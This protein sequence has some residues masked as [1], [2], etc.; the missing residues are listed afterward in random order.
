MV[1]AGPSPVGAGYC[2]ESYSPWLTWPRRRPRQGSED[3][4]SG[5]PV[6][7]WYAHLPAVTPVLSRFFCLS[8]YEVPELGVLQRTPAGQDPRRGNSEQGGSFTPPVTRLAIVRP[9]LSLVAGPPVSLS[10]LLPRGNLSTGVLRTRHGA[11]CSPHAVARTRTG[12]PT[13]SPRGSPRGPFPGRPTSSPGSPQ[14][15][16]R[17]SRRLC[18]DAPR[19]VLH[20][21]PFP[22]ACSSPGRGGRWRPPVLTSGPGANREA[23]TGSL[24]TTSPPRK[25]WAPALA[26]KGTSVRVDYPLPIACNHGPS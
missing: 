22:E 9:R 17:S 5:S 12:F 14:V 16:L 18:P 23:V 2:A 8:P 6:R 19:L 1:F 3:T 21:P 11:M 24:G 7:A 4:R 15:G 26:P 13:L 10:P 20:E 25:F